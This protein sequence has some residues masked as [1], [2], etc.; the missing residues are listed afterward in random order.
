[1]KYRRKLIF[2]LPL[3]MLFMVMLVGQGFAATVHVGNVGFDTDQLDNEPAYLS[4][5]I[6]YLANH[7]ND[8]IIV[9]AGGGIVFD[10]DAL[11][12]A[13]DGTDIGAF[14]AANPVPN[15]PTGNIWDGTGTPGEVAE[16]FRVVDIY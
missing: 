15:P 14:V 11:S 8:R 7:S 16:D 6:N 10:A 2:V 5:F 1:M 13:P 4:A 3:A 12:N 9:N